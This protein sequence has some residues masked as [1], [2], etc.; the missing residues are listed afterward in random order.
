MIKVVGVRFRTAGKIYFFDPGKLRIKIGDFVIVETARGIEFGTVVGDMR[1]VEEDKVIQPLEY[2]NI[3][4]RKARQLKGI[5]R[6]EDDED[7]IIAAIDS[8]GK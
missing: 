5:I 6:E 1:D 4:N 2:Y 7:K 8:G 3:S